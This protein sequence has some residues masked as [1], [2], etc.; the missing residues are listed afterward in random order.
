[1]QA[2]ANVASRVLSLMDEV[3]AEVPDE[4]WHIYVTGHSMGGSIGQLCAYEL[5]CREYKRVKKPK[6]SCYTFGQPRV[7][8]VNFSEDYGETC[9]ELFTVIVIICSPLYRHVKMACHDDQPHSKLL[10]T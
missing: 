9:S 8:N 10:E 5:S 6:I 2:Y 3:L 7:G 1:M 4:P